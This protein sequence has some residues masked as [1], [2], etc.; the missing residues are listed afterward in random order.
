MTTHDPHQQVRDS[1][2]HEQE[3]QETVHVLRDGVWVSEAVPDQPGEPDAW[4]DLDNV[5]RALAPSYQAIVNAAREDERHKAA[6]RLANHASTLPAAVAVH[7]L[8]AADVVREA[9]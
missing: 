5:R 1:T 2:H 6:E 9:R 8:G 4:T 3:G 7:Y